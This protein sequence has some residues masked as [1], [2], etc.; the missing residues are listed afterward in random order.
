MCLR[1][2]GGGGVFDTYS[3]VQENFGSMEVSVWGQF[4]V[5]LVIRR[6]KEL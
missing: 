5:L 6:N 3:G 2:G 4:D 1:I